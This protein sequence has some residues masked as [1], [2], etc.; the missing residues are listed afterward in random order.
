MSSR[1]RLLTNPRLHNGR[2]L[3]TPENPMAKAGLSH[4]SALLQEGGLIEAAP[5]AQPMRFGPGERLFEYIGFTGCAVQLDQAPGSPHAFA[6]GLEG[7]FEAPQLRSGRNSRPP[8]CPECRSAV[9]SWRQQL[10][11]EMGIGTNGDHA[12]DLLSCTS[13]GA[14]APGWHWNWGRHAGFGRLFIGIEPVFPGE[15]R[16]LPALFNLL[17]RV[18]IGPWRYFYIQD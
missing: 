8:R 18:E 9:S 17:E 3:L 16:P 2:L 12:S 6:M 1:P 11:P 10:D 14:R 7:P 5:S 13:C 4:L 15:G